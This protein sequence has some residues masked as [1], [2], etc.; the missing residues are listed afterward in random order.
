MP[1]LAKFLERNQISRANPLPL[2]HTTQSY[3]AKKVLETGIIE[4]RP[5]NVFAGENLVYMFVGRAAYK[6]EIRNES[7]YWEL[8][9]CFVFEYFSDGVKRIFPFDSGSFAKKENY[10]SYFSMMDM[11]LFDISADIES[12]S[13]IIGTFFTSNRS[14]YRLEGRDESSFLSTFSV[15]MLDEEVKAL[16]KLI[17]HRSSELDDRRFAIEMQFEQGID[18]VERKCVAAIFPESYLG[19]DAFMKMMDNYNITPITYPL[20]PLRADYYY[21]TIYEKLDLFY[22][23]RGYY[24]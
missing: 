16:H 7:V 21:S 15:D 6:K 22:M 20:Y 2:V 9:T 5:C 3:F 17:S 14:Y 1:I 19:S 8:P 12:P 11:K 18:L 13:K 10:P 24:N 23:E 4:T